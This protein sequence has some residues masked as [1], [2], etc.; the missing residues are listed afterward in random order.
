MR[1]FYLQ[2]L[3]AAPLLVAAVAALRDDAFQTAL[4][5]GFEQASAIL[6]VMI[7][8][9]HDV[10]RSH[11][12]SEGLLAIFE[13]HAMQVV[14]VGVDQIENEILD[15]NSGAARDA[16]SA[17]TKAGSLLHQ[18]EG[19]PALFVQGYY[20]AV[21]HRFFCVYKLGQIAQFGILPS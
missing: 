5:R 11:D 2:P 9:V 12:G 3:A 17:R 15:G 14:P 8:V 13:I 16:M 20:F 18:A 1:D 10:S 21:E 7:R 4:A 19:G 6:K